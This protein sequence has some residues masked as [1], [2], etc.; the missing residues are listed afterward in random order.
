MKKIVAIIIAGVLALGMLFLTGCGEPV[1]AVQLT[2]C[3]KTQQLKVKQIQLQAE[4]Q[5]VIKSETD[6]YYNCLSVFVLIV[7]YL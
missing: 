3:P 1:K 6:K 7:N 5:N 4:T 2:I